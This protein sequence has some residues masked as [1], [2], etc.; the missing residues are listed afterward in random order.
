MC[1]ALVLPPAPLLR[2]LKRQYAMCCALILPSAPLNSP[3]AAAL[4]TLTKRTG[5]PV[6]MAPEIFNR[7]YHVEAD[8][9]SVGVMLYQL[10][11]RRF[12]FWDTMEVGLLFH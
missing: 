10:Y 9:W 1:C 8:M 4:R 12:P 11:A 6:F 2:Y 3:F 7:R 5:T